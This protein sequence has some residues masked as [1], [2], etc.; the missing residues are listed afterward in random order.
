MRN[1]LKLLQKAKQIQ[2]D[3]DTYQNSIANTVYFRQWITSKE[4]VYY[5][6]MGN[7]P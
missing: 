6:P 5:E 3:K 1:F 7:C 4:V 2:F